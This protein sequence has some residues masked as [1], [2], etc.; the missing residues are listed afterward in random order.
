MIDTSGLGATIRTSLMVFALGIGSVATVATIAAF[1]G[2]SWWLF[3]FVAN[4]RW[5]LMWLSLIAAVIYGLTQKGIATGVFVFA[6][7]LNAWVL[8]PVFFGSQQSGTGEDGVAVVSVDLS[9]AHDDTEDVLR[10]LFDSQAD[11]LVVDGFSKARLRPITVEGSPYQIVAGPEGD[12]V[13]GLVLIARGDFKVETLKTANDVETI[14]VV[15]VP[16]GDR[17]IDIVAAASGLANSS[18]KTRLLDDRLALIDETLA[19]QTTPTAVIGNLGATRFTSRIAALMS[20]NGLRDATEGDGYISTWPVS[21]A[22]LI[23]GWIG[24]PLHLVLLPTELAPLSLEVGPD[25]GAEHLPLTVVIGPSA[26]G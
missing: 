3:D 8:F 6:V 4:F 12:N 11:L 26:G 23:G 16:A 5:H 13:T 2:S 1:F 24:V 10:F 14:Y 21:G 25:I 22:P 9:G 7:V 15:S 20:D 17:T 18:S 19:N